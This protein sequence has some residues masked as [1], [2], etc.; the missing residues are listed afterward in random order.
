[1]ALDGNKHLLLRNIRFDFLNQVIYRAI[2]C[3]GWAS[4]RY[5][6]GV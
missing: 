2:S 6:V 1:M 5:R 3:E 4:I